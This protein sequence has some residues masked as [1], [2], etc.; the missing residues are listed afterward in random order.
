MPSLK[1]MTLLTSVL[2]HL[3]DVTRKT[4][5]INASWNIQFGAKVPYVKRK[6]NDK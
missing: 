4:V 5:L 2:Q 3:I 1:L 6:N